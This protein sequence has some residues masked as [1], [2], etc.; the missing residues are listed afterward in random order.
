MPSQK[1]MEIVKKTADTVKT[2]WLAL[3]KKTRTGIIAGAAVVV[4]SAIIL[5]VIL[6]N[7]GYSV[8]Y[9]NTGS[10]EASEILAYAQNTLGA[11]DI[12]YTNKNILVPSDQVEDLRVKLSIAGYP[13]SSFNY[14]I[15]DEGV[16][17]FSTDMEKR[18]KQKQQLQANLMATL[19]SFAGVESSIV[20]L[21]IPQT[22]TYVI[23]TDTEE[24]SASVV[25]HLSSAGLTSE[26]V[27]GV[28]NLV[29]TSVP[30]LSIDNI[31]VTDGTGA[32]MN[33]GL[34]EDELTKAS[35]A[36]QLY[37]KQ[38]EFSE[39]MTK[40]LEENINGLFDGV[41]PQYNFAVNVKLDY[42]DKVSQKTEYTPSVPENGS[43]GGMISESEVGTTVDGTAA[44][45]GPVGTD[46]NAD[47]SP[48]Y[49]TVDL[50]EN[51]ELHY[52]YLKNVKY[53]VNQEVTQITSNGYDVDEISATVVVDDTSMTVAE[54]EDWQE[55]IA[56]AIG[57]TA[58]K[59]KFKQQSFQLTPTTP[60]DTTI[61]PTTN[62]NEM[63]FII[64]CL[65]ALL[66]ILL[67]LALMTAGARKKKRV[68]RQRAAYAAAEAGAGA[69]GISVATDMGVRHEAEP[70]D[71]LPSLSSYNPEENRE[72]ILKRE[73]QDFSKTNPEIVAQLIRTWMRTD[74]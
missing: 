41:F 58:D 53:L 48:D 60:G 25:L 35:E 7:T 13:K 28:Y 23:S 20:L 6:N 73:I 69:A 2:K 66:I 9:S 15:W 24:P 14:N 44:E 68:R 5:T 70:E 59:V 27:D 61:I 36:V 18:E 10:D 65:G 26:Q 57:T 71:P 46:T 72:L 45:G 38:L 54:M 3:A 49:P 22:K 37:Y 40:K 74:D 1:P 56:Y 42:D 4:V 21:N 30:G 32:Q 16:G 34:S 62:R 43:A 55:A 50:G 29:R 52:E 63:I 51:A 12:K 31:T 39:Q 67:F 8:L 11:T 64:I 17:M 47:I 33:A 19:N